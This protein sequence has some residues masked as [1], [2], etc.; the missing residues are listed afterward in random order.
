TDRERRWAGAN[1]AL[2]C[3]GPKAIGQ[4]IGA[5]ATDTGYDHE[6][7]SGAVIEEIAKMQPR[8]AV[9][10]EGRPLLDSPSWVARWVAAETLTM[11]KSKEDIPALQK[12]T[13]DKAKLSFYWG[14]Q[15]GV[16]PK[17]KKPDPTLGERVNELLKTLNGA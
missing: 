1:N 11:M 12:L 8:G 9:L 7:M 3:G 5:M 14:D 4:V 15:E 17:S 13:T 6:E 2:R 16:D 10:A